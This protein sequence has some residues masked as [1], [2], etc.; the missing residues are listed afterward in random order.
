MTKDICRDGFAILKRSDRLAKKAAVPIVIYEMTEGQTLFYFY[1]MRPDVFHTSFLSRT[2]ETV[3]GALAG[4]AE[5]I[6]APMLAV[7]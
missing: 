6:A 3:D 5:G 4:D 2:G 1:S 7:R